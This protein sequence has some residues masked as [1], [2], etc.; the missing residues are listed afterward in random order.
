MSKTS[1]EWTSLVWNPSKGCSKISKECDNC[2]AEVMTKRLMAMGQK[3]YAQ[4]FDVVLEHPESLSEPYKWKTPQTVFVNSMSDLFHKDISLAFIQMVFK[5]MN[6]TPQHTYQILTKRHHE[7]LKYSDQLNWTENIWMGVS[8]GSMASVRKIDYLRKCGAKHKFLSV[9]PLIEELT[10]LNLEGIDLVF[11]GGESGHGAR[12]MEKEWVLKV[13]EACGKYG[14]T[15][16]FKQWG[17]VASNPDPNDPTINKEHPYH[18]KGG[19]LLDGKLY[20]DNPS[21]LL[22]DLTSI[23]IF[24]TEYYITGQFDDLKTI[25]E[26]ESYLPD[27]TDGGYE[28][29]KADIRKNG[30]HDPILYWV[31]PDGSKLVIDGHTRLKIAKELKLSTLHQCQ[32]EE[33]FTSLESI[34]IWMLLTQFQRRNLTD[35]QKLQM[36]FQHRYAF[37]A[38]AKE[39]HIS[40]NKKQKVHEPID[41]MRE[42]GKLVNLSKS[43]TERYS[44]VIGS[45]NEKLI[46]E[47]HNGKKTIYGAYQQIK[48]EIESNGNMNAKIVKAVKPTIKQSATYTRVES[49]EYGKDLLL[50]KK[51]KFLV[52][53]DNLGVAELPMQMR[54]ENVGVYVLSVSSIEENAAA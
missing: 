24:D 28:M 26:L 32:I 50:E 13:Q 10:D 42:I 8:V 25:W 11:V 38:K 30:I 41:T 47:L 53:T 48:A 43:T 40:A 49:L 3:K 9:E 54:R 37:E 18:A 20:R 51:L 34:K 29:L 16:F 2:Y 45:G 35:A 4:G 14:T 23:V 7:L 33:P 31:T 1:I 27:N 46:D 21:M 36:A 5:V 17:S 19:C 6:D 12:K 52:V 22:Q 39:N 15:F 44:K